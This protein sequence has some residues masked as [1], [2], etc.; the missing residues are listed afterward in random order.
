MADKASLGRDEGM[1]EATAQLALSV[2]PYAHGLSVADTKRAL[3]QCKY[4]PIPPIG[5]IPN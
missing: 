3:I 2:L 5:P 4:E 1:L